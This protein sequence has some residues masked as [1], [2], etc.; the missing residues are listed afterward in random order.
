MSMTSDRL[1]LRQ[2]ACSTGPRIKVYTLESMYLSCLL[3][4]ELSVLELQVQDLVFTSSIKRVFCASC[5]NASRSSV[6]GPSS[7]IEYS[8]KIRIL[9]G[10][11]YIS[12][13]VASACWRS[14]GIVSWWCSNFSFNS[15]SSLF[16]VYFVFAHYES[17]S[18][19]RRVSCGSITFM[20]GL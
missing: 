14:A 20:M 18:T 3:P 2:H 19:E 12:I 7:G 6:V 9:P 8:E 17:L 15:F 5:I 10:L 11:G 4:L 16:T 1:S 13:S